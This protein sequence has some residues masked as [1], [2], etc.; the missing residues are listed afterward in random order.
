LG[1]S[2]EVLHNE[3]N[4]VICGTFSNLPEG[5]TFTVRKRN[6]TMTFKINYVGSEDDGD[7]NAVITRIS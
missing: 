4:A 2:F 5:A 6:T 1:S 3:G 7:H